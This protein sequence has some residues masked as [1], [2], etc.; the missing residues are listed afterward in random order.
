MD[1]FWDVCYAAG[2]T[3]T[4][5]LASIPVLPEH[6]QRDITQYYKVDEEIIGSGSF[7]YIRRVQLLHT[8]NITYANSSSS[9]SSGDSCS[10][11]EIRDI[12]DK[13]II[14][15]A[16]HKPAIINNLVESED[17]HENNKTAS[18]KNGNDRCYYACK[19][20]PKSKLYDRELLRR[21]VYNLNRCQKMTMM[22]TTSLTSNSSDSDSS[23]SEN[24]NYIIRL[25]DV[26]EDRK[27]IHII[28]ELCEGGE[29]YDYIVDEHKRTGRGL[30]GKCL[31]SVSSTIDDDKD[32]SDHDQNNN[33]ELRCATIIFQILT[34]FQF[35]HDDANIAH[36]DLKAS[37][38]V[39]VR[40]PSISITS[41]ELRIIDFGLSKYVG[42][43]NYDDDDDQHNDE[44][45]D[46][47]ININANT[48]K[49]SNENDNNE[50]DK[51]KANTTINIDRHSNDDVKHGTKYSCD[52]DDNADN[53]DDEERLY[54]KHYKFMTSEVGTPYYVA[55]EVLTQ[56]RYTTKCDI[57]S[58]G[59]LAYLTLT[60]TLPVMGKDELETI[61]KLMNP[62]LE[63][64][65]SNTKLWY[66]EDDDVDNDDNDDDNNNNNNNNNSQTT[67]ITTTTKC[68]N[69]N[70]SRKKISRSAQDFCRALLQHD[71]KKR[72]TAKQ[73]LRFDWI[74]KHCGES[75]LESKSESQPF[76]DVMG[77]QH[78]NHLSRR[79]L[80]SLSTYT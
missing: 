12:N 8:S 15:E 64:D 80:P 76:T 53:D 30:R 32:D 70:K 18:T 17:D 41:L 42:K 39:F 34:A 58:I 52:D 60:G 66:Q 24:D 36:R 47:D 61:H 13:I 77:V 4:P 78:H 11:G 43:Q 68:N 6:C 75:N 26:I 38:F 20:I 62:N 14:D 21:E 56:Q 48:D 33:E 69:K 72:P 46:N 9:S 22:N 54:S 51:D 40:K 31:S 27:S 28:T 65:F 1:L 3:D 55:P 2:L 35:L 7:G 74:V 49:D 63:V 29:L 23:I 19:T 71:P 45:N 10:R 5:S 44:E 57:W 59:V 25:L 50:I 73:A 16:K 79:R 37:N 67:T